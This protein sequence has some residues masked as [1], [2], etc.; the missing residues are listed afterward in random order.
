MTTER[1]ARPKRR[2]NARR[3]RSVRG[4]RSRVKV[5]QLEHQAAEQ[6]QISTLA[7]E[8]AVDGIF[9]IDAQ[10]PFFPVTYANPAF[11]AMTG[12]DRKEILGKNYF[13]LYGAKAE[14]LIVQRIRE[15]LLQGRSFHGELLNFRKDG[16]KYWHLLRVSPVRD[17]GGS[18]THYV[19]IQTDVTAMRSRELEIKHQRE[20]LL[21]VTRIGK[22]AEF[23]S[24]LAHEITQPL[25][26]IHSYAHAARRMLP[27]RAT[28]LREI[29]QYIID[30]G[31]RAGEVI[32]RL[33]SLLKKVEPEM[34]RLDMNALVEETVGLV[35]ADA[36]IKHNI[37]RTSLDGALPP[38][39]GDRIQLQ[40]V[41]LNL[42]SNSFD[43]MASTR[44]FR[45][46][47]ISTSRP[48]AGTIKVSVRD[49]GCGIPVQDIPRLFTRFFTSKPDGLGMGLPISRSII[50]THG[51]AL[52]VE[53]NP[54]HGATFS[55][56]LPVPPGRAA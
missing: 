25:T 2:S 36:N 8:S 35:A 15:T 5:R 53:N 48:D 34:R 41:L 22:L 32:R 12:Y 55:F 52:G 20:E 1:K 30:D 4:K 28:Q 3:T 23:V 7:M 50:E 49:S 37:L 51:G 14:P 31:Q 6:I 42:I 39:Y 54:D 33:R 18:I 9:M 40:Q 27:S 10:Q 29:L 44:D 17:T 38:V 16:G 45:E 19:G 46:V 24:S 47:L 43:A 56:T 26:A 21:H 11:R 13:L